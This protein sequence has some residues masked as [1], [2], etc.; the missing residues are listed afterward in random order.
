MRAAARRARQSRRILVAIGVVVAGCASAG[1]V[2]PRPPP[3][4]VDLA[5]VAAND[6]GSALPASWSEGPIAQIYVRG[7]KD[8]NGDGI[9]DLNGLAQQLDYLQALGVTGLW[10]MP[11]TASQDHDHGYAVTDH[12]AIE[13]DY[14]TLA[15]F[16]AL[17]A[18]AHA[19]GIA[20]IV[21][22][23]MNHSA[24]ENWLFA[25]ARA[26]KTSAWRDWYVWSDNHPTGWRIYD[27]DPWYSTPTGYYF[28][29]FWDQMPDFNLRNP[30]VVAYHHDSLRFWLNR[31]V[32]GFRFDAVANLVENGPDAWE[33]QPQD[34]ALMAAVRELVAG[35]A[36]RWIVCEAPV[37]PL[38]FTTECGS[39]FAFG[40]NTD[41][42]GAARGK[43]AA[44]DAV[45]HYFDVTPGRVSTMLANHDSFAGN[46]VWDQLDGNVA[47]YRL[48]AATYL[49]QPGV[50]FIYYGEEIGL[51]VGK[52]LTGD[53]ALRAP[54]SWTGG[55]NAGFSTHTPF[56][57]LATNYA[58]NNVADEEADPASLLNFYK[59]MIALRRAHPSLARGVAQASTS[60]GQVL[61]FKRRDTGETSLVVINYGDAAA[62][63]TF[64]GLPPTTALTPAYPPDVRPLAADAGGQV[65]IAAPALSVTV[66]SFAQ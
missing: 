58:H 33:D 15:D 24:A 46:R 22:Y 37:D 7:Y 65:T 23:V 36:Q 44:I 40:H 51:A 16:D 55:A 5:P 8:S 32:D 49:L 59:A 1:P 35:Y 39:A 27:K 14:G 25:A 56:R 17:V 21:D 61:Q 52:G 29:G 53:P 54:M 28:A 50:P 9:G 6:P 62:S 26:D 60:T 64:A 31:G 41:L 30:A 10:L 43:P 63:A 19:H 20:I 18:T 34:R 57:A 2:A 42:I 4:E 45:A 48:A 13:A 11:I 12:R 3:R 38:G 47:R 66:Y